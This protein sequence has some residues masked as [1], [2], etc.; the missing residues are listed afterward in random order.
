MTKP[1]SVARILSIARELGP[2]AS[3]VV[4]IGGAIAPL[5]HTERVLPRARPTN[6][7]DGVVAS[8]KYG[9][10]EHLQ[11]ELRA[12]GFAHDT[13][14]TG[15][16]HRWVSPSGE[17]F[18]LVPSGEHVGGSG[19]LIDAAA[20][21]S[22]VTAAIEGVTFRHATA[23]AFIAMKVDAFKD[24]GGGDARSSHDIEDV[25][26]LVAS[27]PSIVSEVAVAEL[28]I[29]SRI[30]TF[31][32]GLVESGTLEEILAGHLNN[33]DDVG[34]AVRLALRRVE[35]IAALA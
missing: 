34:S 13:S 27:R 30:T 22:T 12:R 10:T 3:E 20:I 25:V 8:H 17:L 6:D 7:V 9:D 18:D 5:L 35:S 21:A 24:R 2:L 32:S 26:A 29:Q 15:H 16:I 23:P 1:A 19:N 11:R 4:F 31:A 28:A 14:S 33:A